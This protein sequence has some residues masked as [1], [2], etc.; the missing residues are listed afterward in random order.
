MDE[1]NFVGPTAEDSGDDDLGSYG[2]GAAFFLDDYLVPDSKDGIIVE[3][4]KQAASISNQYAQGLITD[5]E[6]YQR[7][8]DTWKQANEAVTKAV[9][10]K[11]PKA[12][13]QKAEEVIKV[14]KKQEKLAY[15]EVLLV[16]A[17]KKKLEVSVAPDGK[18][19]KAEDKSKEK[20]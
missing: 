4:E 1:S 10:A 8:V 11:Y 6:R 5:D 3:G 15:Y 18:I 9:E 16:T 13:L 20:E 14:E 17:E 7:T 19:V 12:T 2:A